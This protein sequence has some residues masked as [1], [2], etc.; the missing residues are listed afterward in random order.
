M[1]VN[2]SISKDSLLQALRDSSSTLLLKGSRRQGLLSSLSFQ[3]IADMGRLKTLGILKR[4][5]SSRVALFTKIHLHIAH[6]HRLA[7]WRVNVVIALLE[8]RTFCRVPSQ[9]NS[10]RVT[11]EI[12]QILEEKAVAAAAAVVCAMA[13]SVQ[14]GSKPFAIQTCASCA[15]GL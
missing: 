9:Q 11:F 6:G 8:V 14:L 10:L 7:R 4:I 13:F 3:S 2:I 12:V 1:V 15:S 5:L